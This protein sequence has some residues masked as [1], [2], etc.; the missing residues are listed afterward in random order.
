MNGSSDLSNPFQ[1]A[2]VLLSHSNGQQ[3]ATDLVTRLVVA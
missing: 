3:L 2:L 1:N